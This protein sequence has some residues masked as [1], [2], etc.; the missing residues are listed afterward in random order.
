MVTSSKN[1]R[2]NRKLTKNAKKMKKNIFGL[3]Q[4]RLSEMKRVQD[5]FCT[6][7]LGLCNDADDVLNKFK[8]TN[9]TVTEIWQRTQNTCSEEFISFRY[10]STP[11]RAHIF[12]ENFAKHHPSFRKVY[13]DVP[14][15]FYL[16]SGNRQTAIGARQIA[17][18]TI[19]IDKFASID[20]PPK[21]NYDFVGQQLVELFNGRNTIVDIF[22]R[23]FNIRSTQHFLEN[24]GELQ[25]N[26]FPSPLFK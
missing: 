4:E 14:C 5:D 15:G 3:L 8:D 2:P 23:L 13:S 1:K 12:L 18:R 21:K 9:P 10:Y 6:L 22:R 17:S 24:A 11:K 20:L 25:L 7:W 16:V 19:D 26:V